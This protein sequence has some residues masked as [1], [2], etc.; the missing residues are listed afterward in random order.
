MPGDHEQQ[1]G[2]EE[3]E[4]LAKRRRL[5]RESLGEGGLT[6]LTARGHVEHDI[7]ASRACVRPVRHPLHRPTPP[8]PTPP[9]PGSGAG[10]DDAGEGGNVRLIVVAS[11]LACVRLVSHPAPPHTALPHATLPQAQALLGKA[12][13]SK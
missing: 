9:C 4:R 13:M 12:A 3:E 6:I 11:R 5:K 7:R 10:E 2:Q 1:C 8:C